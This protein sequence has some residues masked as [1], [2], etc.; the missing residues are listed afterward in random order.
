M[1]LQWNKDVVIARK[2]FEKLELPYDPLIV[3]CFEGLIEEAHPYS[4]IAY[5]VIKDMILDE[6]RS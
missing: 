6:V 3:S 1:K 4:F 5:N 2:Y